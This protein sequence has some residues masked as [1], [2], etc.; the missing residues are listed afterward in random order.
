MIC[1]W[2]RIVGSWG[3]RFRSGP[4]PF[5][6]FVFH[7]CGCFGD[8]VF[9]PAVLC[10]GC[11]DDYLDVFRQ[12]FPDLWIAPIVPKQIIMSSSS[13]FV[14]CLTTP[15]LRKTSSS[16]MIGRCSKVGRNSNCW[17]GWGK[18]QT[19]SLRWIHSPNPTH[20]A[21]QQEPKAIPHYSQLL[22]KID[23]WHGW[24]LFSC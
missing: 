6:A 3:A 13:S 10:F 14:R 5:A 19:I 17:V 11:L 7:R 20:A 8:S 4:F 18:Q 15:P 12:S 1:W 21:D 9:C 22:K 16:R 23:I 2:L 24:S